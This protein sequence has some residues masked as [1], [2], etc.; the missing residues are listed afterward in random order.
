MVCLTLVDGRKGVGDT[1]VLVTA[2][3]EPL[4]FT[5]LLF[6]AKHYFDSEASCYPIEEGYRGK[7]ML[8][9]AINEIACGVPFDKVLEHYGLKRKGKKLNIVDKRKRSAPETIGA[10][11]KPVYTHDLV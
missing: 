9:N 3:G 5:E 10:H 7:A 1:L 11:E 2:Y 8:M 6:L 4:S